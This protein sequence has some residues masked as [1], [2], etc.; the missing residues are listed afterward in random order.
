MRLR[1]GAD[2]RAGGER[3]RP[4]GDDRASAVMPILVLPA[5]LEF[6]S[7]EVRVQEYVQQNGERDYGEG[8]HHGAVLPGLAQK[9][10]AVIDHDTENLHGVATNP[11][12]ISP[13]EFRHCW[14]LIL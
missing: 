4:A 13:T 3:L 14:G 11:N 1:P 10:E 5:L 7:M 8:N 6:S 12:R 9:S 2:K